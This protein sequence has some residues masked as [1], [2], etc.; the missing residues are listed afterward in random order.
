MEAE[1]HLLFVPVRETRSGTLA[2]CTARLP[3]GQ[4]VGL[5]FTS[6]AL[7]LS[8]EGPAQHWIKLDEE[9]VHD[10]L[11]PL[12]VDHIRV[13]PTSA[14]RSTGTGV[15][16]AW[17][18][19]ALGNRNA[20]GDGTGNC[21]ARHTIAPYATRSTPERDRVVTMRDSRVSGH[22]PAIIAHLPC[23]RHDSPLNARLDEMA[24]RTRTEHGLPAY[25]SD[26]LLR[27]RL[28]EML[29][30]WLDGRDA[31]EGLVEGQRPGR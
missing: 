20:V 13:D 10:L 16:T 14:S 25:I 11:A 29:S 17:E 19:A 18:V 23:Q 7:L 5:A 27:S 4:R 28:R 21:A 22:C 3:S 15:A 31:R 8:V 9:A 24:H 1:C 6:Q 12:G 2:L 30:S 26:P